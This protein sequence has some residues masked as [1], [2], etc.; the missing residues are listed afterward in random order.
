[1]GKP[2]LKGPYLASVA[3]LALGQALVIAMLE[4][5]CC[6]FP[7]TK[8]WS[9]LSGTDGQ[10]TVSGCMETDT[11][12]PADLLPLEPGALGRCAL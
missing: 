6:F 5:S 9:L 4:L 11:G 7:P 3:G 10:V 8:C 1:M 2:D 12:L